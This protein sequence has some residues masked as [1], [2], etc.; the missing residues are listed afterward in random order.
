MKNARRKFRVPSS[1]SQELP[2]TTSNV[3]SW[4]IWS[5]LFKVLPRNAGSFS[6]RSFDSV[7]I[8]GNNVT[9][10][11]VVEEGVN[12][13]SEY[14]VAFFLDSSAPCMEVCN[15]C[16]HVWNLKDNFNYY[17]FAP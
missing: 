2:V 9:P 13:W 4:S 11:E 7:V 10:A 6:P 14:L 5:S 16:K 12:Y 15:Q 17:M 1:P 8:N 3:A